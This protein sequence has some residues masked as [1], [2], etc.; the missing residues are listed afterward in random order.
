[1]SQMEQFFCVLSIIH[2]EHHYIL[3]LY[4]ILLLCAFSY[5]IE[6]DFQP[7]ESQFLI[8]R[9]YK[10]QAH[11][12]SFEIRDHDSGEELVSVPY[13]SGQT[14]FEEWNTTITTSAHRFD[15]YVKSLNPNWSEESYLY[16]YKVLSD[17]EYEI[18]TRIRYDSILKLPDSYLLDVVSLIPEKSSW[19]Y[20]MDSVTSNWYS[21]EI[22]GWST[23]SR[24]SFPSSTNQIQL[25]KTTFT[26]SSLDGITGSVLM[27]RYRYGCVIFMNEREVF[28]KS[29]EGNVT[30]ESISTNDY[31]APHFHQISLPLLSKD[32]HQYISEGDN[33]VAIAIIGQTSQSYVSDFDCTLRL[34]GEKS[35]SRVFDY[36]I[37][38]RG[39]Y[40]PTGNVFNH[41]KGN[42][43]YCNECGS[44]YLEIQFG[45]DRHEWISSMAAQLHYLQNDDQPRGFVVKA[46]NAEDEEWTLIRSISQLEWSYTGEYKHLW[47][48]NDHSYNQYR[49]ENF[50]SGD[51]SHCAWKLGSLFLYSD[52]F[53]SISPLEYPSPITAFTS[54]LMEPVYP[55]S[56]YYSMF[57]ITPELP[58]GIHMNTENGV[59]SGIPEG[60]SPSLTYTITA[61]QA[62]GVQF[63]TTVVLSIVDCIDQ[64]GLISLSVRTDAYPERLSYKL[65]KGFGTSGDLVKEKHRFDQSGAVV[66]ET[67][68]LPSGIF[69]F[70][71]LSSSGDGWINPAGYSLSVDH[72]DMKFEMGQVPANPSGPSSVT[73]T[74]SSYLPF[75]MDSGDSGW[76]VEKGSPVTL[77]H[78]IILDDV[79]NY[80]V[81]NI[82]VKYAGGIIGYFNGKK[83]ARFNLP[84][85]LD[86]ITVP[87]VAYDSPI[88]SK[89]HIILSMVGAVTGENTIRFEVYNPEGQTYN[90]P[91]VFGAT[92]VFGVN[93]CSI[94]VDSYSFIRGTDP[95]QGT[96]EDFFDLTTV[97]NGYQP[98]EEG[99]YIE[100]EVENLEG[101]SLNS[102]GVQGMAYRHDWN[103][104]LYGKTGEKEYALLME[105]K[106]LEVEERK[107]TSWS[108][109]LS[110]YRTF[111]WE[112]KKPANNYVLLSAYVTQYCIEKKQVLMNTPKSWNTGFVVCVCIVVI[113]IVSVSMVTVMKRTQK[114]RNNILYDV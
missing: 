80:H 83:V 41:Y 8:Q 84:E 9:T 111:K 1:M 10:E 25:Y 114:K 112:V 99:V 58:A 16:I 23:G 89:F 31:G 38:A 104:N 49:F 21:S 42:N 57:T 20:W 22:T 113:V 52:S 18:V 24:D 5:D 100:W 39:I 51:P 6:S 76:V 82:R 90:E 109:A 29:I 108:V 87:L 47:L 81:L 40:G 14:D 17:N 54:L 61:I 107:R 53:S 88:F 72:G 32:N 64:Y 70:Q 60:T 30:N 68:C 96:L 37:T 110:S 106:D 77:S 33:V 2:M 98:N 75:I 50:T 44:N 62:T 12:E 66:D 103:A 65:F 46:K 69:T 105:G 74:F 34:M 91:I 26:V 59:I 86:T 45:N 11:K 36:T 97:T 48:F 7:A 19:Y 67:I 3:L 15:V 71:F 73:T 63:T 92:G 94:G 13:N 101:S 95:T 4:S 102:F 56:E 43:I 93:E 35:V 85:E 28:R 27:L 55:M 79:N 78:T